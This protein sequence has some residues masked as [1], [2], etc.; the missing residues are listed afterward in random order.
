M[1]TTQQFTHVETRVWNN[2]TTIRTRSQQLT[3]DNQQKYYNTD[4]KI[5]IPATTLQQ[6]GNKSTTFTTGL[7]SLCHNKS[8]TD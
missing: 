3:I 4:N 7:R 8:A 1:F 2:P 6:Q 5:K